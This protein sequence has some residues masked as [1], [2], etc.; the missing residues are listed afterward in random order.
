MGFTLGNS[1]IVKHTGYKDELTE[2]KE[3]THVKDFIRM[4]R[5]END[6]CKINSI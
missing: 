5:I 6:G 3:N 4:Q 2:T 1:W